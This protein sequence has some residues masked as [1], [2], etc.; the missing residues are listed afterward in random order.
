MRVL[1]EIQ[2]S[3]CRIT[4]FSW[5]NRYIIKVEQGLLEQTFKVHEY[6]VAGDEDIL[7]LIDETFIKQTLDRFV[8]MDASLSEALKRS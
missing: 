2:H 5:N 6:D 8:N 7:K 4:I 1:R 3:D